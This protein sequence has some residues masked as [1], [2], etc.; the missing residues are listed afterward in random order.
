MT[1]ATLE[2]PKPTTADQGYAMVRDL[3][4]DQVY[5]F[6]RRYGGDRDDL[7]GEAHVAF[8]KGHQQYMRGTTPSGDAIEHSY[9][10]EIRRWVWFE[11]FDAMRLRVDRKSRAKMM[12]LGDYDAPSPELDFNVM[13]FVEDLSAD[14]RVAARMVLGPPAEVAATAAAK[15]GTPRNFRSTVRAYLADWGWKPARINAAFDEITEALG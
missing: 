8:M 10:V 7:A 14:A 13:D 6:Q 9:A 4:F 3:I 11:M 15:G 12:P 5:K 1:T 2:T